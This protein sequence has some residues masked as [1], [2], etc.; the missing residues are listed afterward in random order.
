MQNLISRK[1]LHGL[2]QMPLL[3]VPMS[4]FSKLLIFLILEDFTCPKLFDLVLSSITA[5]IT[6]FVVIS[7]CK[8]SS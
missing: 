7:I 6:N 5:T 2:Y 8:Y 3:A 1:R 4:R